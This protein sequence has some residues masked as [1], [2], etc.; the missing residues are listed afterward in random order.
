[1]TQMFEENIPIYL[2]RLPLLTQQ[3]GNV[4]FVGQNESLILLEDKGAF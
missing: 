3:F 4:S 1:M 2:N